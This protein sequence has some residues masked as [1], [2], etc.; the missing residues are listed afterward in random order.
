MPRPRRTQPPTTIVGDTARIAE[1]T[2]PGDP[3]TVITWPDHARLEKDI[4]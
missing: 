1:T 3:R 2:R 4:T